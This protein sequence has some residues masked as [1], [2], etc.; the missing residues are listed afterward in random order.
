MKRRD[1][2]T[3]MIHRDDAIESVSF[4]LPLWLARVLMVAG[5]GL[6]AAIILAIAFYVPLAR[7]A[8]RVPGLDRQVAELEA[9]NGRVRE[10]AAAL[11]SAEAGYAR[12]RTMIGGDVVPDPLARNSPL[13]IAP[14]L[15]ALLPGSAPATGPAPAIPSRWPLDEPGYVTRGQVGT[16]T[17]DEAHPGIDIAV[18]VG[19]LVRAS[20]TGQVLEAGL[21]PQYGNF[22]LL[23]HDAGYQTMYGHL[24]RILVATGAAVE[25][26]EV[27]GLSGNTGRSSA[28]HLHF[29]VRLHGATVDPTT[30]VKEGN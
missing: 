21:D 4:R 1:H 27:I 30:L 20:A 18:P 9:E 16:G 2:V 19:S 3:I 13:P 23:Q 5:I 10:L 14:A 29:E 6:G 22:V 28:P 11:D 8:A 24:S 15:Q 25:A 26:G 12:V 7:T 17:A